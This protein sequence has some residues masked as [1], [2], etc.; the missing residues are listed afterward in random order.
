MIDQA[1]I[2]RILDAAQIVDVVSDFVT[3]R[4]RGVNYVDVYKRQAVNHTEKVLKTYEV[5]YK[6]AGGAPTT[7]YPI[8]ENCLYSIGKKVTGSSTDGDK[9]MDLSGNIIEIIVQDYDEDYKGDVE[10]PPV[11]QPAYIRTDFN[12][13]KDVYKRQEYTVYAFGYSD[14][15][16]YS[17][18]ATKI[19]SIAKDGDFNAVTG[20]LSAV[21][22]GCL[23]YTS[24]CV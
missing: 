19:T 9:P 2:D 11:S 14:N 1:T 7:A 13:E 5:R 10:F 21:A 4:K 23:L 20:A 17:D 12:P 3:L 18:L 15:S 6:Q 22:L 24:R 8:K 16:N